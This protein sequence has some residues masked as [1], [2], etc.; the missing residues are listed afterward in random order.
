MSKKIETI[1]DLQPDPR[2]ANRG[3]PR[4]HGII[5]HS[6]RKHGA[7]RSGLA[8]NDGTMIAGSQTLE[9]M[10]ALGIKIKPVH[11]TGDEWVV[12][13]RDDVEA[14]SEQAALMALEDNRAAQLGIDFDP[15]VLAELKEEIDLGGLFSTDELSELLAGV[16]EPPDIGGGGDDFDEPPTVDGPTRTAVGDLWQIGPHRL[17]VGDCTDPLVVERLMGGE[18]ADAVVCDLPYGST[19]CAWDTVIP[20]DDLWGMYTEHTGDDAAIVLTASQ[21]FTSALIAG[22][23]DWFRHCWVWNKKLSGNFLLAD[24]QPL[25]IHEDVCVFSRGKYAYNPQMRQGVRRLKGGNGKSK[26]WDMGLTGRVND[27]YYPVSIIEIGNTDRVGIDHPTQKP[28]ELFE[29]LLLTYSNRGDLVLD[30]TIGSGTTL[31]AAHSTGRRC[32]G[33]ELLPKWAD[34][35]LRRAEAAG[36][37]CTRVE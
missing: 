5:E 14:G 10:A 2:N 19:G 9:E 29:Y 20:F 16:G 37:T 8:A 33:V 21:P 7:G 12:V 31:A 25:K 28:L 18:R 15:A 3:T 1:S 17:I 34:T 36:L 6:I 22:R 24:R 11:T 13:I 26:L 32:F 35:C 27:T 23:F 30:N 4:G